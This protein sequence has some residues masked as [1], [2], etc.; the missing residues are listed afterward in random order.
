[1]HVHLKHVFSFSLSLSL[2]VAVKAV[3]N[4]DISAAVISELNGSI[5]AGKT[6]HT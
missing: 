4:T 6:A 3:C 1:M 2:G 5:T